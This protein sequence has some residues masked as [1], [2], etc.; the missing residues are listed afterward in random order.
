MN[1]EAILFS[2]IRSTICGEAVSE[3]L[4][5]ACTP[6]L[7]EDVYALASTHDLAHLVGQALSKLDLPESKALTMCKNAA[8][9]AFARY[10]QQERAYQQVCQALEESQIPFLPLKG[11]VLRAYY[12][13]PWMRT[14]CDVDILVQE[15]QLEAAAKILEEAMGYRFAASTQHDISFLS[16]NGVRIELHFDLVEGGRANAGA[17]VLRKVWEEATC[18]TNHTFWYEM[19]D[20]YF[21]FYHIVHMAKHF[22]VNG[23]GIRPILDLWLLD[24]LAKENQNDRDTLLQSVGLLQFTTAARKLSRVWFDGEGKDPLS[25]RLQNFLLSGGVYGSVENWVVLQKES[26]GSTW[27]YVLSR[28]FTPYEV[29]KKRYPIL[30]KYRW[31]IPVMQV[32]RWLTLLRPDVVRRAKEEISVSLEHYETDSE[33]NLLR[34]L[35][36]HKAL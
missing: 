9:A 27:A 11:S 5:T 1:K 16:P 17:I 19:P 24:N 3:E 22:E 13:E 2:L 26:K 7:L 36:I 6:E 21:Y 35:G 33:S 25:E 8:L 34:D 14:S 18:K 20:A 12:P 32:R 10:M 15:E 28:I 30:E 4:K 31:L 23:C 29:L